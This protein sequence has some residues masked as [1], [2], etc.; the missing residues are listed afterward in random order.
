MLAHVLLNLLN[1]LG[2]SDK[3]LGL[4]TSGLTI[5][6]HGVISLPDAASCDKQDSC[7]VIY[8]YSYLHPLSNERKSLFKSG[9]SRA[10]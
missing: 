3:M 1:E 5:L 6:L 8:S 10:V 2:K 9:D 7:I 4:P